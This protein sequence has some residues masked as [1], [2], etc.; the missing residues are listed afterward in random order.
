MVL[1]QDTLSSTILITGV[2]GF[3]GCNLCAFLKEKDYDPPPHKGA[4]I[5]II[6]AVRNNVRDVS[7]VD[8]YIKAG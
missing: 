8:G 5:K 7:G 1:E 3:I 2:N 4:G 6:G